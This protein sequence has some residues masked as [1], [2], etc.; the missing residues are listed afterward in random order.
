MKYIIKLSSSNILSNLIFNNILSKLLFNESLSHIIIYKSN[1]K[2]KLIIN[3]DI[4]S[5][6]ITIYIYYYQS[7]YYYMIKYQGEI[8]YGK[9]NVNELNI[10]ISIN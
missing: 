2:Y 9:S 7:Y 6:D 3:T 8:Y 1:N 10:N 5:I 4:K